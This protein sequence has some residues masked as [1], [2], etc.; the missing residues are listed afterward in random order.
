MADTQSRAWLLGEHSIDCLPGPREVAQLQYLLGRH[1]GLD[2]SCKTHM[3]K[4][5]AVLM[6]TG[7]CN[8]SLRT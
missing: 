6:D 4:A 2:W 3:K 8:S 1:E 7:T 5:G